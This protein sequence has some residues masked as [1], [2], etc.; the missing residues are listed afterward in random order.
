MKYNFCR[1]IGL[2]ELNIQ[3]VLHFRL[4]LPIELRE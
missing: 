2:T 4:E 3:D 1:M